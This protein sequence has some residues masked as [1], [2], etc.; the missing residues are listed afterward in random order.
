MPMYDTGT[1]WFRIRRKNCPLRMR[2]RRDGEKKK[3]GAT[4]Y[5]RIYRATPETVD[6]FAVGPK[7][8]LLSD[9]ER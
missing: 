2:G 4:L 7:L 9:R 1:S 3:R 6:R 8:D 5:H